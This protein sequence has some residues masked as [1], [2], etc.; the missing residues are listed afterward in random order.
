[1]DKLAAINIQNCH[2]AYAPD[3]P[4]LQIPSFVI[5]PGTT[6]FLRGP[7]GSGKSTL[8]QL[9]TGMLLPQSGQIH[10][11]GESISTLSASARDRFRA[12]NIGVVLQQFN[13]IDYLSVY[14]NIKLAQHFTHQDPPTQHSAYL[15]ELL[16]ALRLAPE[17]QQQKANAL[18]VGQQ[19]RV[20][21]LRALINRPKL[22]IVDEPTSALDEAAKTSFMETLFTLQRM[23]CCTLLFVS[24]D[25]RLTKGFDRV[26]DLADI[27]DI[28][29]AAVSTADTG[30]NEWPNTSIKGVQ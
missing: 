7:S 17:I 1:M 29:T 3:K 26:V 15:D 30:L 2:F 23:T 4:I 11:L 8:L 9:C 22:L 10:V 5:A 24:H 27:D 6:V 20:A 19:Q 28:S 14:D 13:L 12:A 25:M 18:S 16:Q 21:I